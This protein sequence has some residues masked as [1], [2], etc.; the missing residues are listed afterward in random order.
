MSRVRIVAGLGGDAGAEGVSRLAGA[1]ADE[2]FVGFVPPA[3]YARYGFEVSPNRRYRRQ[4]QFVDEASIEEVGRVAADCGLL[5]RV[6]LNEHHL[7]AEQLPLAAE[8]IRVAARAGARGVLLA[9]LD[10]APFVA[11]VAPGLDLVASGDMPICNRAGL[12]LAARLGFRRVI[13]P[14]ETTLLEAVSLISHARALGL[15]VEAFALGEWCVYDG[16]TCMTSHGYGTEK[17]FCTAHRVRL[18]EDRARGSVRP[19]EPRGGR[20][21]GA[22][23]SWRGACALCALPRL[24]DAGVSHVKVPGRTADAAPA[25]RLVRDVLD[26]CADAAAVRSLVADPSFC[27]G[28]NCR[29]ED[30]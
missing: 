13:L 4:N 29:Y 19:A 15:D 9:S 6:A 11:S 12:D 23:A 28:A 21:C 27:D 26:G 8:V 30:W 14:R 20:S 25:V 7:V 18:V 16:A 17:D 22:T 10:L 2:L 3:W 5:W 24:R 1:G